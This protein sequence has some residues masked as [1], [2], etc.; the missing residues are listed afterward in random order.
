[1]PLVV[2]DIAHVAP[3]RFNFHTTYRSDTASRLARHRQTRI[4]PVRPIS[5][6]SHVPIAYRDETP[7]PA[8]GARAAAR[9]TL[10]ARVVPRPVTS[11]IQQ[12]HLTQPNRAQDV[13]KRYDTY[14][15]RA[16][17]KRPGRD[18]KSHKSTP[19]PSTRHAHAPRIKQE[20]H[21]R[22]IVYPA[23]CTTRVYAPTFTIID[24]R[25]RWP[26]RHP[27]LTPS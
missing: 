27:N 1:M 26:H 10:T 8:A 15:A 13:A 21:S 25:P 16:K 17:I 11:S 14:T 3:R 2:C 19:Q 9:V 23:A 12:R 6:P 20:H 7:G 5:D 18:R 22:M 24:T 4:D